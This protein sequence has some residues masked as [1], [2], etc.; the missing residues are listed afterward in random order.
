MPISDK[1]KPLCDAIIAALKSLPYDAATQSYAATSTK[2]LM[3]VPPTDGAV[4]ESGSL[5]PAHLKAIQAAGGGDLTKMRAALKALKTAGLIFKLG[6]TRSTTYKAIPED[7]VVQEATIAS[8]QDANH[9]AADATK[10]G[11]LPRQTTRKSKATPAPATIGKDAED[12][13]MPE[14]AIPAGFVKIEK[15]SPAAPQPEIFDT[16]QDED[17]A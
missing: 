5:P 13:P 3:A 8:I 14:S 12:G 10:S 9:A 4:P 15:S 17:D 7:D 2:A 6:N 11:R 16:E 1:Q